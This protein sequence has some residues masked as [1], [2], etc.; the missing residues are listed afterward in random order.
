MVVGGKQL[1]NPIVLEH[2]DALGDLSGQPVRVST[3]NA[4]A[5]ILT[6]L[7]ADRILVPVP[8]AAEK[9][10]VADGLNQMPPTRRGLVELV[11]V[12]GKILSRVLHFLNP[13]GKQAKKWPED[14]FATTAIEMLYNLALGCKYGASIAS[15]ALSHAFEFIPIIDP[16]VFSGEARY[17]LAELVFLASRYDPSLMFKS[18]V[19]GHVSEANIRNLFWRI[20]D[21][22]EYSS[23]VSISGRLGLVR[24][25]AILL[26][27]LE[28]TVRDLATHAEFKVAIKAGQ[29]AAELA[30][31]PV[32]FSSLE[33]LAGNLKRGPGFASPFIELPIS[34]EYHIAEASLKELF[35][36][37]NFPKGTLY[38]AERTLGDLSS[39][40]WVNSGEDWRLVYHPRGTLKRLKKSA[41][42]T[43][44]VAAGLVKGT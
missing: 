17:R 5:I 25:P 22:S 30:K 39:H 26:H 36:T 6:T 7:G 11:D 3:L 19:I 4:T 37:A 42:D 34:T 10:R 38:A 35:P 20:I 9:E 27:K 18:E 1:P 21:S 16:S 29:V 14:A 15:D 2:V 8:G 44:R 31:L 12:D 32:S 43:C 24:H 13:I 28:Q 41:R 40:M 23:V 33:E